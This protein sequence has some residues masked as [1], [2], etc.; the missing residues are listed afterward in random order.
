MA[1]SCDGDMHVTALSEVVMWVWAEREL[2]GLIRGV[3]RLMS[4][5]QG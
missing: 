1:Q 5:G 2:R 4:G 3:V